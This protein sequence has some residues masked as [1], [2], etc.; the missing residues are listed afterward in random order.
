MDQSKISKDF[1]HFLKSAAKASMLTQLIC[2]GN[3][4]DETLAFMLH[5]APLQHRKCCSAVLCQ[6]C[7]LHLCVVAINK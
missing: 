6:F 2:Y 3:F 1:E 7:W 4:A 5:L